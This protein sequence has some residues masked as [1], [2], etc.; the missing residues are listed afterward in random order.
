VLIDTDQE[1]LVLME[2][3]DGSVL[4]VL[5]SLSADVHTIGDQMG[6][7]VTALRPHLTTPARQT[8]AAPAGEGG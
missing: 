4:L 7:F 5:A 6:K 1:A 2:A 3:G 8:G